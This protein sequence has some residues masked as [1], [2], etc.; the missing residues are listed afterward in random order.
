MCTAKKS[1]DDYINKKFEELQW[2][3]VEINKNET[4]R[5]YVIY[6]FFL[7]GLDAEE[8][9]NKFGSSVYDEYSNEINALVENELIDMSENRSKIVLTKKGRKYTDIICMLFW[10]DDIKSLYK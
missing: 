8:Y 2:F 6:S 5:R 7:G 1:I 10:S 3:G 4:K 9:N